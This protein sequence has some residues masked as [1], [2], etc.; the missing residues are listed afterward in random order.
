MSQSKII[1]SHDVIA[2]HSED[3]SVFKVEPQGVIYPEN[4]EEIQEIIKSGIAKTYTVRAGGTC[5][6]GGSLTTGVVL[7]LTKHMTNFSIDPRKKIAVVEMGVMLRDVLKE[8]LKYNL[9][10]GP[11]PSSKD[12]CGV[13]GV[14]GNNASG[15]KSI[16]LGATI[17][18]VLGLEVVLADGEII[19]TGVLENTGEDL[20]N[21]LRETELKNK[22][23]IIRDEVG[24]EITRA[25]GR[26]PKAASGYRLER[27]KAS[28]E[29]VHNKKDPDLTPLFVGAQGTLGI[30]TKAV[31]RLSD[32]PT[33]TRLLV[34]SVEQIEDLPFILQTIMKFHPEG[35]ETFDINTFERAKNLLPEDTALCQRFFTE[36]TGLIVLAQFSENTQDRTDALAREAEEAL[37]AKP[38]KILFVDDA[39]LHDA[40]WNIRRH[41]FVVMKDYNPKGFRAVPCIEDIIAPIDAFGELIPKLTDLIKKYNLSYGFHGHIGEGSLRIVPIFDFTKPR[42]EVAKKIIDFTREVVVLIKSLEGNMSADHS[43]GIIRTPFLR[44][45]YGDKVFG[46]FAKLKHLFDPKEIFNKGK[47]IGGTEEMIIKYLSI[48]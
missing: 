21:I 34:T 26:V 48:K 23:Q 15:E 31:L 19:R 39:K 45:F 30:I 9:T 38:Q 6:S 17:D 14:I 8:A 25:V 35:V 36:K 1:T 3:V 5:M 10:F 24:D 28:F 46:A 33:Y 18:N 13:G 42:E 4:A 41:S 2:E 37:N 47:K 44:E 32:I 16:R 40:V 29:I 43:D 7:N 11:Y 22:V 20:K 12:I 27:I